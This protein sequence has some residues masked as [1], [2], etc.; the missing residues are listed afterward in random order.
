MCAT[1]RPREKMLALGAS[2]LG[3]SELLAI[4][5]R[6]GT[7]GKSAVD[8]AGELLKMNGGHLSQLFSMSAERMRKV[9]GVGACKAATLMAAVEL[10][11]RFLQEESA[12]IRKSFVTP[13]MVFDHMI[14]LIK[15][16]DHEE[17]WLLFLNEHNYL[18]CKTK[19]S[20]GCSNSTT[21]D[22]RQIVR[23]ALEN[24]AAGVILVHNHPSGNPEPSKAD[25]RQT[26]KLREGLNTVGISLVDHV[27]IADCA[28][29][30]FVDECVRQV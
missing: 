9:P 1:E 30:S 24:N 10:G 6:S 15:G 26:S 20:S 25:V 7:S 14:P 19:V 5:L 29:Y 13:R 16:I 27:V 18:T 12:C 3:N 23:V 4:L 28:F 17:C 11:K 21:F 2:A 22:V 8:T